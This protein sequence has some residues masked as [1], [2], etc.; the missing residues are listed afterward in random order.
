MLISLYIID[1]KINLQLYIEK[2]Q[3]W[4]MNYLQMITGKQGQ[5]ITISPAFCLVKRNND[6]GKRKDQLQILK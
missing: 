5:T 4:K 3:Q 6:K 2:K 1:L